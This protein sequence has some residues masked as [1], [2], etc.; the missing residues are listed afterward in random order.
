MWFDADFRRR[1]EVLGQY[2]LISGPGIES[3]GVSLGQIGVDAAPI[4][5]LANARAHARRKRANIRV[6]PKRDQAAFIDRL[7][8][9]GGMQQPGVAD[10]KITSTN[11]H[12]NL[13]SL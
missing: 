4:E 3:Q 8:G 11:R 10:N 6:I 2:P 9:V 13:A 12:S 5:N 1:E 7:I